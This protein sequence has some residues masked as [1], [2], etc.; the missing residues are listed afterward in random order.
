MS[1]PDMP[2]TY[3]PPTLYRLEKTLVGERLIPVARPDDATH[4]ALPAVR[5]IVDEATR[6]Q[7]ALQEEGQQLARRTHDLEG[8]LSRALRRAEQAELMVVQQQ[9]EAAQHGA[10][11]RKVM[12]KNVALVGEK[13]RMRDMLI[14]KH[15]PTPIHYRVDI[16]RE[17][18]AR[19]SIVITLDAFPDKS[20]ARAALAEARRAAERRDGQLRTLRLDTVAWRAVVQQPMSEEPG[21][22]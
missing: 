16:D 18:Q 22:G 17:D 7:Q 9:R 6:Q 10:S 2:P 3:T 5:R 1:D 12:A 8:Q 11:L 14:A 4:V 13:R 21:Q 15:A 20:H 19:E